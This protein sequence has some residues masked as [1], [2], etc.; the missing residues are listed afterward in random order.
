[1]SRSIFNSKEIN[2]ELTNTGDSLSLFQVDNS[3]G[4]SILSIDTIN[5]IVTINGTLNVD[6]PFT[7][8][9]TDLS[10]TELKVLDGLTPGTCLASKALVVD[11][12]KDITGINNITVNSALVAPYVV[13]NSEMKITDLS[14]SRTAGDNDLTISNAVSGTSDIILLLG[15]NANQTNV[16]VKNTDATSV[17]SITSTGNTNCNNITCANLTASRLMASDGS[18]LATSSDLTGWMTVQENS[19]TITG[20]FNG[21]VNLSLH[22][23]VVF[24]GT[25]KMSDDQEIILGTSGDFIIEFDSDLSDTIFENKHATGETTFQL[26]SDT[27]ATAFNIKN[28]SNSPLLKVFGNG[29]VEINN[30]LTIQTASNTTIAIDCTGTGGEKWELASKITDGFFQI[31]NSNIAKGVHLTPTNDLRPFNNNDGYLGTSGKQWEGLYAVN[32]SVI[33]SDQNTKELI[34]NSDLGLDFINRLR[35]VSYKLKDYT[36]TFTDDNGQQRTIAHQYL[37]KHYGMIAQEVRDVLIDISKPSND[38]AGYIKTAEDKY[39][40][41]YIEFICPMMKAIQ[42]LDVKINDALTRIGTLEGV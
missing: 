5:S 41:R 11:S 26:G 37:R 39:A 24:P 25:I 29:A 9:T 12:S 7:I 23:A 8:G 10:E 19:L 2:Q 34:T 40:L 18:K 28:N 1:M 21:G 4:T 3:A 35:P 31:Y 30:Q 14:I 15:D 36:D 27:T 13:V 22:S 20:D 16:S 38:F 6:S 17:F 32:A 33:S 42:E